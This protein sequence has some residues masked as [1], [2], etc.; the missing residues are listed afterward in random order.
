[1]SFSLD[2]PSAASLKA[3]AKVLRDERSVAGTPT[4]PR[5]QPATPARRALRHTTAAARAAGHQVR[6]TAE[7]SGRHA[8]QVPPPASRSDSCHG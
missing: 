7:D 2:T 4:H 8:P 1:M 3:E 6:V 5:G